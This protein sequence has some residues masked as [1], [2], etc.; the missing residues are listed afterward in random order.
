MDEY[1]KTLEAIRRI[2]CD[3]L[4]H[5]MLI[6]PKTHIDRTV[7]QYALRRAP[8]SLGLFR[9]RICGW[10][11]LDSDG[12]PKY[13]PY[14]ACI[15]F[16]L[17]FADTNEM[18][19]RFYGL[20]LEQAKVI[21][22]E[23]EIVF[24]AILGQGYG[25]LKLTGASVSMETGRVDPIYVGAQGQVAGSV[26]EEAVNAAIAD[27]N[28]VKEAV[29]MVE[30]IGP[31]KNVLRLH[32]ITP[33]QLLRSLHRP[34]TLNNAR[35]ALQIARRSV[36]DEIR[37]F[38]SLGA[39]LHGLAQPAGYNIDQALIEMVGAQPETLSQDQRTALNVIRKS[40]NNESGSRILLNGDVGCGKTLVFLLGIAAVAQASAGKVA[41]IVPSDLVAQQI[42]RE[43][44][45]R[46]AALK[47]LLVTASSTLVPEAI[48]EGGQIIIGTQ[49]LLGQGQ[50]LHLKALVIDE[51]HKFSVAQRQQLASDGTHIIEASATPIPR[52]LA[53]ALFDGWREARITRSPVVKKIRSRIIN[54]TDRSIVANIVKKHCA[55]GKRAMFIYPKVKGDGSTVTDAADRLQK[56]APGIVTMLHGQLKPQQKAQALEDFRSG[57][58]PIIV[59]STAV[60][61]GVDVKDI[62]VMVVNDADRF[63]VSQ[64]HQLRGRLVRNG[65]EGDFV[66]LAKEKLAKSTRARLEAVA[67][68]SDGFILAERDLELRGFGDLLGEM[69]SGKSAGTFKLPRLEAADFLERPSVGQG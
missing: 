9:A 47:P 43:A 16:I 15:E 68:H 37:S 57:K 6:L 26:I 64:L 36:V 32:R 27:P 33:V 24:D 51:Q 48:T 45:A 39:N 53:L 23:P 28:A 11:P 54:A 14:P 44:V 40:V 67:Q 20:T 31:L 56:W 12:K 61:V 38:A 60:E 1:Q 58:C 30:N 34:A 55:S 46:F 62:G 2:G 4:A 49:A 10:K 19:V 59:A 69:Q 29:S 3:T 13:T 25:G 5:A 7:A 63:G 35:L 50:G 8:H 18:P 42:H 52:S 41:V 65:G 22:K 66:M 21:G 17:Q